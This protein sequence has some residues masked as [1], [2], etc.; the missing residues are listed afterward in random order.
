M[1]RSQLT[2]V[3]GF[4]FLSYCM[5]DIIVTRWGGLGGIE[6]TLSSFSALTLSVD[7]V[8]PFDP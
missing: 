7:L 8:G 3:A 5:C 2:Q 1:I 4:V 6:A